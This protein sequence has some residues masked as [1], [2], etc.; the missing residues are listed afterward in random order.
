[1]RQHHNTLYVTT[2]RTWLGKTDQA[3]EVKRDSQPPVRVPLHHLNG[4]V[5]F[6][7][8]SVSPWLMAAC[9]EQGISISFLTQNGR[10][11]ARVVGPQK[12]NVLLRRDQYR[13][14]DQERARLAISRAMISAKI[15]N[16]RSFLIRALRKRNVSQPTLEAAISNLK[17]SLGQVEAVNELETLRGLEGAA[18]KQYFNC[19]P[20]IL[21]PS[22]FTWKGRNLRPPLDPANAVLSF[23]YTL[24]AGDCDGALQAVGLDSQVGYLH[25]DKPGRPALAL[26]L[27]EEFRV[28]LA[29]RL[30]V[31]LANRGQLK[32][33]HFRFEDGGAVLLNEKGRKILLVEYQNRKRNELRHPLLDEKTT[34]GL[35]PLIQARLLARHL[36]GDL[37][38]YP[39][40]L[41]A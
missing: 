25:V 8:V 20:H 14:A 2:P 38:R 5:C 12:G 27:M 16:A 35:L 1:M 7:P 22:L 23:A 17:T 37:E 36:R 33:E 28:P 24:V 41:E 3:V 29:D 31:A 9:A 19:F 18:A 40:F 39:P 21:N 15:A 34:Y 10:F 32:K 30:M 26:D 13:L 11:L 6:G 4:I